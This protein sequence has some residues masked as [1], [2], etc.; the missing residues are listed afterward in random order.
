MIR[1]VALADVPPQPWR[2]GGGMTQELLAWPSADDWQA[3]ISVARIDRNGP[4]S[5]YPGVDRWFTVLQGE[6]VVL[7][8]ASRRTMLTA[9]SQPLRFDGEAAPGCE[10]L[11]GPT[12]D[13]N[14]MLRRDAGRG[15][16]ALATAGAEWDV[17]APLR[18]LFTLDAAT[19]HVDDEAPLHLA[20]GTLAF[21]DDAAHQRWRV[22]AGASKTRAWWLHFARLAPPTLSTA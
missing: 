20:A 17:P 6:G 21:D 3:R 1:T 15:G 16:M 18:A 13:L 12:L 14:L 22:S 8:L 10:L 11:E 19:L 4:F 7:R 9:G 5:A 2:N